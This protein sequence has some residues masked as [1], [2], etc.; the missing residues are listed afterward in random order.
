VQPGDSLWLIAKRHLA[1]VSGRSP[2]TL[3]NREIAAYWLRVLA[4]NRG[5]LRSG[6]ADLIYPGEYVRLPAVRG[7]DAA[8]S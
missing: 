8:G 2:R 4:A 7:V 1:H 6:R 3:R 5:H